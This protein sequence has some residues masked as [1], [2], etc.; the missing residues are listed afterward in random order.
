[1]PGP[2]PRPPFSDF[3][4]CCVCYVCSDRLSHPFCEKSKCTQN[5][6]NLVFKICFSYNFLRVTDD[7]LCILG[8]LC[9]EPSICWLWRGFIWKRDPGR[10]SSSRLLCTRMLI[11]PWVIE[12]G[13]L[14]Y[15]PSMLLT[16]WVL[17]SNSLWSPYVCRAMLPQRWAAR[18]PVTPSDPIFRVGLKVI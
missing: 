18:Q 2:Q 10:D 9:V 3:L 13:D 1:M 8:D 17:S 11:L 16:H 7:N 14:A 15:L 12:T 5:C 6:W 4:P